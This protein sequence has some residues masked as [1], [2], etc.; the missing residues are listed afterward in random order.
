MSPL[1][2]HM[3]LMFIYAV[4]TGLF[5]AFLWKQERRERIR[6]FTIVFCSLFLGGVA[7]A[8]LMYPFPIR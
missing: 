2:S 4:L 8:W 6:F 5:F 1:Q 3:M 7:I